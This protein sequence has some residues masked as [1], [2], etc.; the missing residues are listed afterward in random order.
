[1]A[2]VGERV[3]ILSLLFLVGS[4]LICCCCVVE[5]VLLSTMTTEEEEVEERWLP[6]RSL[7]QMDSAS[8][9]GTQSN[10]RSVNRTIA[11]TA[12]PLVGRWSCCFF[13][14]VFRGVFVL[15]GLQSDWIDDPPQTGLD[16]KS[17]MDNFNH[18]SR[19]VSDQ[20]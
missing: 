19:F 8:E 9:A 15:F 3:D 4:L 12:T 16:K 5:V 7:L 20:N 18:K 11:A 10:S 1:M 17:K 13:F 6:A 2:V 14:I